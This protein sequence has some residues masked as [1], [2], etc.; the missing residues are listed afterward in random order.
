MYLYLYLICHVRLFGLLFS[1]V[2]LMYLIDYSR[3]LPTFY[4]EE[5]FTHSKTQPIV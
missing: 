5:L 2:C 3:L 1:I 4:F